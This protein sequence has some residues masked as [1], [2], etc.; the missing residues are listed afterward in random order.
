L[1]DA[2]QCVRRL[3]NPVCKS[4]GGLTDADKKLKEHEKRGWLILQLPNPHKTTV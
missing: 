1:R 2:S 3:L 4:D